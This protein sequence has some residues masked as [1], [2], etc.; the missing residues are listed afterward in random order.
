MSDK[1]EFKWDG[2]TRVSADLYLKNFNKIFNVKERG[3][4]DDVGGRY[5]ESPQNDRKT[6]EN[7]EQ[8]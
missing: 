7:R 8:Q 5:K 2:K 3:Q 4:E 1:K 6:T